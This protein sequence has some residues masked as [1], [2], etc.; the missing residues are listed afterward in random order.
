MHIKLNYVFETRPIISVKTFFDYKN[1]LTR[2]VT[3][4][5]LHLSFVKLDMNYEIKKITILKQIN[6]ATICQDLH[7]YVHAIMTRTDAAL[8]KLIT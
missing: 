5:I 3:R 7:F 1:D 6:D 2:N 4:E 8:V